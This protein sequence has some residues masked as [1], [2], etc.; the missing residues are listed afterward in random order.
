MS[1][2]KTNIWDAI[3]SL[4]PGICAALVIMSIGGC[5]YLW[6]VADAEMK[7]AEQAQQSKPTP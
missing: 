1:E 4:A 2:N 7:K 3:L 6:T 5:G